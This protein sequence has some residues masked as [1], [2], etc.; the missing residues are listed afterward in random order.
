MPKYTA[1]SSDSSDNEQHQQ[2]QQPYARP[3]GPST[4]TTPS[5][6]SFSTASSAL[7]S[8]PESAV[9][10]HWSAIS[11][12]QGLGVRGVPM[13]AGL[14]SQ[15]CPEPETPV[16]LLFGQ[17]FPAMK[18]VPYG[19]A[20]PM[21]VDSV[22][23]PECPDE[24][25]RAT[26]ALAVPSRAMLITSDSLHS[27]ASPTTLAELRS[28]RQAAV[29]MEAELKKTAP[30]NAVASSSSTS[31]IASSSSSVSTPATPATRRIR[32]KAVP[33]VPV[34]PANEAH[35]AS[36]PNFASGSTV[37]LNSPL[38]MA[39]RMVAT[40]PSTPAAQSG[41]Y[42]MDV[43]MPAHAAAEEAFDPAL[44][45]TRLERPGSSAGQRRAKAGRTGFYANAKATMSVIEMSPRAM[46]LPFR[47]GS[48][49]SGASNSAAT[50]VAVPDLSS[51]GSSCSDSS[52]PSTPPRTMT[53]YR[54]DSNSE[55]ESDSARSRSSHS[56]SSDG[57]PT[58]AMASSRASSSGSSIS[59]RSPQ[60]PTHLPAGLFAGAAAQSTGVKGVKHSANTSIY[61][62]KKEMFISMLD[63]GLSKVKVDGEKR[64]SP[65]LRSSKKTVETPSSPSSTSSF[66]TSPEIAQMPTLQ[67]IKAADSAAVRTRSPTPTPFA[68][69]AT[70]FSFR[71]GSSNGGESGKVKT[72]INKLF[73]RLKA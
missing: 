14:Q 70:P 1:P 2:P 25:A 42:T 46:G 32:R 66:S 69:P 44:I 67:A 10:N 60:T 58:L 5:S 4:P 31:P 3:S 16:G 39:N 53:L 7:P 13:L 51:N 56:G 43:D 9:F 68:R 12:L 28:L 34:S 47:F 27:F 50:E 6:A 61:G 11:P 21:S 72:G 63:L 52:A 54:L 33:S 35:L 41:R 15:V 18:S 17:D 19:L 37:D 36:T 62:S 40:L 57:V 22:Y 55:G 71:G 24:A 20:V 38:L 29:D 26:A 65:A 23:S 45:R 49:R 59:E 30:V 48:R 8:T 73:S 64:F